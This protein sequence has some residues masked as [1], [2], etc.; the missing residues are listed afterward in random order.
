[1]AAK[2]N[3]GAPHTW[4]DWWGPRIGLASHRIELVQDLFSLAISDPVTHRFFKRFCW[5]YRPRVVR[6]DPSFTTDV[7]CWVLTPLLLSRKNLANVPARALT[8][9]IDV[10]G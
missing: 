4:A 2:L 10:A 8:D 1:M 3:R 7:A 5:R 9:T 6:R